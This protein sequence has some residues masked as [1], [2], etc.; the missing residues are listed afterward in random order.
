MRREED[1]DEPGAPWR[2]GLQGGQKIGLDL[3]KSNIFINLGDISDRRNHTT[4]GTVP[5]GET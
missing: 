3:R 2:W 1:S 4:G 5:T